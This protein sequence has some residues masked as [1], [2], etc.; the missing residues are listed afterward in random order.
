MSHPRPAPLTPISP[1]SRKAMTSRTL[2]SSFPGA[3]VDFTRGTKCQLHGQS[4]SA[5][6]SHGHP[7]PCT[8]TDHPLPEAHQVSQVPL[9]STPLHDSSHS[10]GLSAIPASDNLSNH[11]TLITS[12]SMDQFCV[13]QELGN[14]SFGSVFK[15]QH[16]ETGEM[17][18]IKK[19]KKKFAS[20]G[21]CRS[22]KEVKALEA[23]RSGPHIVR[24]HHFFLEKK[25]L[26]LVFELMEGNLYQLIKD[27][28]GERLEDSR[29]RS[30]LFQILRGLHHMHSKGIMHRDMKPENLL[31]TDLWA[32]GT[33][34]AELMTLKP[35]FPGNS[36]V[37]QVSRISSVLGNPS[38]RLPTDTRGETPRAD[39]YTSGGEWRDGLQLAARMRFSFPEVPSRSLRDCIPNASEDALEMVSGLLQY[40]PRN[41][42]TSFQALHNPWFKDE[43]EV[44]DLKVLTDIQHSPDKRRSMFAGLRSASFLKEG[45]DRKRGLSLSL[46][47][48]VD[49]PAFAAAA[50]MTEAQH[51]GPHDVEDL[52]PSEHLQTQFGLPEISPISPFWN[53]S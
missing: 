13:M 51:H 26:H 40:E 23:L 12:R 35:L 9:P 22:L 7:Q 53:D 49:K 5:S 18:A 20:Q 33:I 43:P 24:L 3:T 41:R 25:E 47:G 10:L 37:D 32:A 17:F 14:G 6:F 1:P 45:K 44:D 16:R 34:A 8:P 48:T 2:S 36:D 19:M 52:Q 31:V 38:P 15:A 28:N 42:S 39:T 29:I 46:N 11:Q 30:M 27:R 50:K 21:D 4:H